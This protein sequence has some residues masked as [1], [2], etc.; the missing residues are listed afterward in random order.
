[1]SVERSSICIVYIF[2]AITHGC[3]HRLSMTQ[4][5]S[6]NH[7]SHNCNNGSGSNKNFLTF[8]LFA[9]MCFNHVLEYPYP[10][11]CVLAINYS[12]LSM[13]IFKVNKGLIQRR[14]VFKSY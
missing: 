14:L 9:N 2:K 6:D 5:K 12:I 3:K 11:T 4:Y 13:R 7:L 8:V 10:L 1:M